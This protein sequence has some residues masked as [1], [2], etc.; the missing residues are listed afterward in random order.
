MDILRQFKSNL[1]K[2]KIIKKNCGISQALNVGIKAA[3]GKFIMWIG[4]D[5]IL[6]NNF[7]NKIKIILKKKSDVK[8]I[9]TKTKILSEVKKLNY[10]I[11][12]YKFKKLKNLTFNSLLTE[13]PI[14]APGVIF[15]KNF[16]L[17]IGRFDTRYI[18]N[19]DY[20]MWLRMYYKQKP[21]ILN[22]QST[23]YNRHPNSLSSKYFIKQFIEQFYVSNKYKEKKFF[24]K[25]FHLFKIFI[26][27]FIYNIFYY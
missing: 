11:E 20:D 23:Y 7:I 5:D 4:S 6:E 2:K 24:K 17:S 3:S 15:S 9:I 10:F 25:I 12:K 14:S 16:F 21:L 19:S 13:N 1:I 27:I 18:F 8:W 26:I 22:I